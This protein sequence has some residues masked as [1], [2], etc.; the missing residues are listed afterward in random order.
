MRF[1]IKLTRL[2]EWEFEL[3]SP[4]EE[5][6]RSGTVMRAHAE[7]GWEIASLEDI[8]PAPPPPPSLP[9]RTSPYVNIRYV[10]RSHDF[11][12][13]PKNIKRLFNAHR[14]IDVSLTRRAPDW[15]K[16]FFTTYPSEVLNADEAYR[17]IASFCATT[18]GAQRRYLHQHG[19][20][21]P[22]NYDAH[23]GKYI[24]R[25]N[26]H[27]SGIGWRITNDQN[28]F[29]R[30][31]EYIAPLF[32]K[33]HEYRIIFSRGIVV[34]TLKKAV[35]PSLGVDQPWNHANGS[36]FVTVNNEENN[37]LRHT[38][39]YEDLGRLD[40][41]R[42]ADLTGVDVLYGKPEGAPAYATLEVNFCPAMTIESNL[43]KLKEIYVPRS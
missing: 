12:T 7:Q 2:G 13:T 29:N 18:K 30:G 28:D 6:L 39:V 31:S 1:K 22:E 27:H 14:T 36:S 20:K 38:S 5:A 24:V 40:I 23:E 34:C 33:R 43:L 4:S 32:A 8:T 42:N 41:I 19:I 10:I 17:D 11:L 16:D 21:T 37:R 25:P 35:P 9:Q 3:E 26:R 15:R